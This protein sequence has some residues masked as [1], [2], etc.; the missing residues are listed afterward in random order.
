MSFQAL[1]F[2]LPL[3]PCS[4]LACVLSSEG[5]TSYL[6]NTSSSPSH[7]QSFQI[8]TALCYSPKWDPLFQPSLC[9]KEF[10]SYLSPPCCLLILCT[11]CIPV[12][13]MQWNELNRSLSLLHFLHR[14]VLLS[15][16]TICSKSSTAERTSQTRA[17]ELSGSHVGAL[18][19]P[20][21]PVL[22][23]SSGSYD[24][25]LQLLKS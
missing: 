4:S 15:P 20:P 21:H 19:C 16:P 25:G 22:Q 8:T 24:E 12:F 6:T 7:T 10:L 17:I 14:P 23:V 11:A 18:T 2:L 13:V 5:W 1:Y 9:L 3:H